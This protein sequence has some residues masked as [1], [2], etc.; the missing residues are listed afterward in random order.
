LVAAQR[1]GTTAFDA[2]GDL[3]G[4]E[5]KGGQEWSA[6][7][8]SDDVGVDAVAS[9]PEMTDVGGTT[10]STDKNGEWQAE[11]AWFDAP[12]TQGTGGG[13]SSLF[14]RPDWQDDVSVNGGDGRRLTPDVAAVADPFTG[15]KIVFDQ[16]LVVG[17]GTSLSAPIWAGFGALMNQFL[18]QNGGIAMG[19]VNPLLYAIAENSPHPAFRDIVLGSNA[20]DFAQPGYDLVTGIGTPDVVS[21]ARNL[22][23][24]QK[25]GG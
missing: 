25:M 6:P 12:L 16:Q 10:L 21:L 5:C 19:N 7:P 22:L 15:V 23:I 2:S 9:L 17:G 13:V 18:I 24:A 1:K 14:D 20:V 4:M 3:A 8:H 11:Q